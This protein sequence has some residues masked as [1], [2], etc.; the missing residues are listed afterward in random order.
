MK[1]KLPEGT[2]VILKKSPK[3]EEVK[4]R[5]KTMLKK[6]TYG[7]GLVGKKT[8]KAD[9]EGKPKLFEMKRKDRKKVSYVDVNLNIPH[10]RRLHE[11]KRETYLR[12]RIETFS[13]LIV[14]F[15]YLHLASST[16][17]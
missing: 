4:F 13:I 5:K 17:R 6:K 9:E 8:K 12:C 15:Y 3:I 14:L 1:R 11:R 16:T 7:T 2:P 10:L